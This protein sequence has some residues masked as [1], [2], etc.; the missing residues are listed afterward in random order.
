MKFKKLVGAIA[1]ASI[2]V[3]AFAGFGVVA[4]AAELEPTVV[5]YDFDTTTPADPTMSRWSVATGADA[6]DEN[7]QV[8]KFT[9]AH[10]SGNAAAYA[11]YDFASLLTG[12]SSYTISYDI[13]FPYTTASRMA[14]GLADL[15]NLEFAK[16]G[17][18]TDNMIGSMGHFDSGEY[19]RAINKEGNRT[20]LEDW[21]N[22][23]RWLTVTNTV[24][25]K[26]G[27]YNSSIVGDTTFE[28][29]GK[30]EG[31]VAKPTALLIYGYSGDATAH[32][33]VNIDNI[34]ITANF[35]PMISA[36]VNDANITVEQ[37]TEVF[38]VN[39]DGTVSETA[40]PWSEAVT[41]EVTT[42]AIKVT[43]PTEGV[44]PAVT[45]TVDGEKEVCQ[46]KNK[47]DITSSI[48][49]STYYIY[50]FV[51]I[52]DITATG[53]TVTYTGAT[54]FVIAPTASAE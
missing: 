28:T 35:E 36:F 39:D 47:Q 31:K 21:Q 34:K 6:L 10:N 48:D 54:D 19:I 43:N 38:A 20:F 9:A 24:N 33:F 16:Q 52:D 42:I 12:A 30:L 8:A 45:V 22:G 3:S 5:T 41:G 50:Q 49:G 2:A 44:V 17:Y 1:A 27:T 40:T 51:G 18:N 23:N 37:P 7:N 46:P 26:N 13:Y 11:Y 15:E 32:E 14:V 29:S 25:I 53:A 4:S